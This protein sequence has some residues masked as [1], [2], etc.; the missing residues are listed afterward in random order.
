[1][2]SLTGSF[3]WLSSVFDF[4]KSSNKTRPRLTHGADNQK[5]ETCHLGPKLF[6]QWSWTMRFL[7]RREAFEP[8][9][10]WVFMCGLVGKGKMADS[11]IPSPATHER[12]DHLVYLCTIHEQRVKPDGNLNRHATMKNAKMDF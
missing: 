4:T 12:P 6:T 8:C 10:V 1:M 7:N 2:D 9:G 5:H 11:P 3:K